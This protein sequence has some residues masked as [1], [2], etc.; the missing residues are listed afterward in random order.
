MRLQPENFP[1][2]MMRLSRLHLLKR[3][4]RRQRGP[5]GPFLRLM[6]PEGPLIGWCSIC[7]L[8][9]WSGRGLWRMRRLLTKKLPGYSLTTRGLSTRGTLPLRTCAIFTLTAS[10]YRRWLVGRNTPSPSTSTWIRGLISDQKV[11]F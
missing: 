5:D 2:L 4:M 10:L 1:L 3:S 6:M 7:I 9:Q 11:L 8:S